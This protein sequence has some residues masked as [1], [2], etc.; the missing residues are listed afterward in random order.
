MGG[1]YGSVGGVIFGKYFMGLLIVVI[2]Y[3]SLV[4]YVLVGDRV[5]IELGGNLGFWR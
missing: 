3:I 4:V 5:R 1:F 2:D